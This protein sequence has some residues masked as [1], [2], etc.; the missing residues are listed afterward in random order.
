MDSNIQIK[1]QDII[2]KNILNKSLLKTLLGF[3]I[4]VNLIVVTLWL[5][6]G[7]IDNSGNKKGNVSSKDIILN[8]KNDGKVNIIEEIIKEETSEKNDSISKI[9]T[10]KEND[11][12]SEIRAQLKQHYLETDSPTEDLESF[13]TEYFDYI[14][15]VN[16]EEED[17]YSLFEENKLIRIKIEFELIISDELNKKY[18]KNNTITNCKNYLLLGILQKYLEDYNEAIK[19]LLIAEKLSYKVDKLQIKQAI[20]MELGSCYFNSY[21][22]ANSILYF[23]KMI[24]TDESFYIGYYWRGLSNLYLDKIDSAMTDF[25]IM[26]KLENQ[27]NDINLNHYE[28]AAIS[29]SKI[30][31]LKYRIGKAIEYAEK[32]TEYIESNLTSLIYIVHLYLRID[33][34]IKAN[35]FLEKAKS[36]DKTNED[37]ILLQAQLLREEHK[38]Y[39]KALIIINNLLY[40]NPDNYFAYNERGKLFTNLQ[41]YDSAFN[42]FNRAIEIE[43]MYAN[44]YGNRGWIQYKYK[45]EPE[46]AFSD[47]NKAIMLDTNL[48]Y[49]YNNRGVLYMEYYKNNNQAIAD[50]TKALLIKPGYYLAYVN[51]GLAKRINTEFQKAIVDFLEA[52]KIDDVEYKAF[53]QL[54]KTYCLTKEYKTAIDYYTKAIDRSDELWELYFDRA[55]ANIEL[56]KYVSAKNDLNK[57]LKL[58]SSLDEDAEFK[59]AMKLCLE[60]SKN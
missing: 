6:Y 25:S 44:A 18:S 55:K 28:H 12:I 16:M 27:Q 37:V 17:F 31:K 1:K 23:N 10:N 15:N 40:T 35:S 30:Y 14:E 46:K 52:I 53:Y 4:L 38:Q 7:S 3:S 34:Y 32:S 47:Y 56:K 41:L 5:I 26:F 13:E 36:I 33:N 9:K 29:M 54:G 22:F 51:R 60:S 59:L 11:L 8:Q 19:T 49:V 43:P 58:N 42:D 20:F 24:K 48:E 21:D 57:S 45:N 50:F 39:Q 2:R